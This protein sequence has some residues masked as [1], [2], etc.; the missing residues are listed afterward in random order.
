[1]LKRLVIGA[2]ATY[3]D[4]KCRSP[5]V[6]LYDVTVALRKKRCPVGS[7]QSAAILTLPSSDTV[8]LLLA[9]LLFA[10]RID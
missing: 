4:E 9:R 7:R 5:A 10:T 3:L 1:M 8:R 2:S 6:L